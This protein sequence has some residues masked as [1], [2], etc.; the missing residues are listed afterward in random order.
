MKILSIVSS[1]R[2]DGNT[3]RTASLIEEPVC[4]GQDTYLGRRVISAHLVQY[5]YIYMFV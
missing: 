2:T 5:A 3:G 1:Y 4:C